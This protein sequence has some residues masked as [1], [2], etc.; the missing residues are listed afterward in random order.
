MVE[1]CKKDY[2]KLIGF[3]DKNTCNR[4]YPLSI[5]EE[6]QNGQ[7][8]VDS[9]D[10]I[11]CALFW[12]QCGFAY[13]SGK[14][15]V[16]FLSEVAALIRNEHHNN[17]RRFILQIDNNEWDNYFFQEDGI[18]REDRYSFYFQKTDILNKEII[19]PDG[20]VMKEIDEILLSKING[21]IIPSF[22]WD[23]DIEFLN[24]GK[25]F[26][27]LFGNEIAATVFS[28]AVSHDEI[29]IGIE[30]KESFRRCGLAAILARRIVQYILEEHKTPVWECHTGNT[31]SRHT[32][33]K[34]GFH[35][36]KTHSFFRS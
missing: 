12:H 33:E 30:T 25:G 31:V 19:L 28:S 21:N 15:N 32:A 27:I 34:I 24:K 6:N 5:A 22:S 13:L 11:T 29:D 23:S 7:I 16:S 18:I 3:A 8:F 1:V 14:P 10:N 35:V 2:H 36:Q 26:C 4:V 9:M 17:L 20:F